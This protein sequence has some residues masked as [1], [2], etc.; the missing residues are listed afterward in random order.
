MFCHSW[1]GGNPLSPL[2]LVAR[3]WII[4]TLYS[5]ELAATCRCSGKF[6][7]GV[8]FGGIRGEM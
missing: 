8:F 2:Q 7:E 5:R 3:G 4:E 6:A 1:M